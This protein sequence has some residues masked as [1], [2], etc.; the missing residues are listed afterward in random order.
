MKGIRLVEQK[1][2]TDVHHYQLIEMGIYRDLSD[3]NDTCFRMAISFELEEGES[4]QYPLEDFL[5]EYYLYV[6][7]F[8]VSDENTYSIELAG[9]LDDI[10]NAKCLFAKRTRYTPILAEDEGNSLSQVYPAQ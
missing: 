8:I 2:Y 9:E 4:T 6:S 7:D 1:K 5:D 3:L 10:R